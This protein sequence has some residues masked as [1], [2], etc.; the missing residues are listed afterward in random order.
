[1]VEGGANLDTRARAVI[2][3][4]CSA[5]CHGFGLASELCESRHDCVIVITCPSCGTQ[6]ALDDDQ[7]EALTA[8]T[9]SQG[10]QLACGVERLAVGSI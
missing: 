10:S 2:D 8:W 4:L 1:M 3:H 7:Y 6:F 5:R 9:A